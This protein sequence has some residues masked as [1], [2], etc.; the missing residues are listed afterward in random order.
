MKARVSV[1]CGLAVLFSG[2]LVGCATVGDEPRTVVAEQE[3]SV[4]HVSRL[5]QERWDLLLKGDLDRAYAYLSEGSRQ[6]RT[7]EQY[8]ARIKPGLWRGAK[9]ESAECAEEVCKVQVRIGYKV[10]RAGAVQEGETYVEERWVREGGRW[11]YFAK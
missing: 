8:K 11:G 4:V 10:K 5:A 2:L 9:V 6:L 3:S 1:L 7:L